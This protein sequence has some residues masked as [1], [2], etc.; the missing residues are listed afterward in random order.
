M[1][2][3]TYH[4]L[5]RK[6]TTPNNGHKHR[7]GR[8]Y[9]TQDQTIK[10]EPNARSKKRE[11]QKETEKKQRTDETMVKKK[12]QNMNRW[13]FPYAPSVKNEKS[14]MCHSRLHTCRP[15]EHLLS[16][17]AT[18]TIVFP[19]TVFF[20]LHCIR[21][22]SRFCAV[23]HQSARLFRARLFHSS[24]SIC[25][26]PALRVTLPRVFLIPIGV[27]RFNTCCNSKR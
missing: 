22:R 3:T 24:S 19:H 23:V 6:N 17:C 25:S 12:T 21:G 16:L 27:N 8:T 13:H 4:C 18:P 9:R 20:S 5:R 15:R 7:V 14:N 2:P 10:R 26:R 11:R 1:S